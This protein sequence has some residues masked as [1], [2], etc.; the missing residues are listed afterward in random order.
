MATE[1][2]ALGSQTAVRANIDLNSKFDVAYVAMNVLASVVACYGLF[3]NSPAV[4]IGAMVIAMLLGPTY[5][6]SLGLVDRNNRLFRKAFATL[7]GGLAVVYGTA[8]IVGI[9][10]SEFPLTHEIYARTAPNL[11]DLMI[12]LGGGAAGAYSMIFPQLN[13]AFVGVAIATALVPPFSAS[14]ICLARGEYSLALGALILGFTNIVAIQVAGSIV[15]W[16]LGY[17]GIDRGLTGS[18]G[19][20]NALS[21]AVKRNTLSIVV[22][23]SLAVLLGVYLRQMVATEVYEASV[24]KILNTAAATHKGA[25]LTDV[26][27]QRNSGRTVVE[28][29]YHTPAPFTP[30]EVGALEPK[31]PVMKG[32]GSPELQIRSIPVT[33]SSTAGYLF[34]SEDLPDYGRSQ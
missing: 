2:Q 6:V 12:A 25:H 29:V 30:E 5:G 14:A 28:A 8:F 10:H 24:R 3:E 31:L 19:K 11:M 20:K 1:E 26:R 27:I 32:A 13:V 22:L 15:M 9:V 16:S 7:A 23:C 21:I 33:V 18:E 17:R 34:S 4:V